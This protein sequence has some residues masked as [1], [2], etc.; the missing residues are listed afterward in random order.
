[1]PSRARQGKLRNKNQSNSP[2]FIKNLRK[3][4]PLREALINALCHRDYDIHQCSIGI[5]IYDDRI[6]IESPGLL[7]HELTPK[8]IKLSRQSFPRNE[9]L[10]NVLYQTTYLEKWGSGVKRIIE[11]CEEEGSP[12]PFWT[13]ETG[14]TV[15]TFPLARLNGRNVLQ[16]VPQNVTQGIDDSPRVQKVEQIILVNS[17]KKKVFGEDVW[18][19]Y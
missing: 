16:N 17:M 11:V 6:E 19:K 8:T 1:M 12:E 10:A 5:A 13:E 4:Y 14:Y 9:V 3:I 7:P 2:F 18:S 15:V